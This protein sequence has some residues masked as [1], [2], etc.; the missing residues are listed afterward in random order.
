MSVLPRA[1]GALAAL[2]GLLLACST[3]ADKPAALEQHR[4]RRPQHPV[5]KTGAGCAA[6]AGLR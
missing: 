4:F 1:L 5:G 2:T 3:T 6:A